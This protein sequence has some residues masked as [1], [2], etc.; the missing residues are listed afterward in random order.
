[1]R[2]EERNDHSGDYEHHRDFEESGELGIVIACAHRVRLSQRLLDGIVKRAEPLIDHHVKLHLEPSR[3]NDQGRTCH[4]PPR[5]AMTGIAEP[6]GGERRVA[7]R[8]ILVEP[9]TDWI[10][11]KKGCDSDRIFPV[12]EEKVPTEDADDCPDHA[13]DEKELWV[14]EK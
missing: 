3:E 9:D 12:A 4:R 1:M 13:G 2:R 8:G 6:E 10:P 11:L 5:P 7:D 14:G